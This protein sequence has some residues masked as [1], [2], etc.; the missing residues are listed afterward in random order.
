VEGNAGQGFGILA[1]IREGY[2]FKN[3]I[4]PA[5]VFRGLRLGQG[6][7]CKISSIRSTPPMISMPPVET[8][9]IFIRVV[10]MEGTKIR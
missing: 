2:I 1:R 7:V 10:A 5:G 4:M 3:D 6:G 8:Y 9:M